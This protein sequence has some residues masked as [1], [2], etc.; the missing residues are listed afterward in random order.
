MDTWPSKDPDEV[1]D[2]DVNWTARLLTGET[3]VSSSF[4]VAV[5]TV[6]KD[7]EGFTPE[8]VATVWLSGGTVGEVCEVLNHITTSQGR[9][10]DKTAKLRI[11]A[12]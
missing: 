9:E 6:V 3:I 1:L 10:Y 8:G 11:R 12:K 4:T 5:G 7:S 2:Y